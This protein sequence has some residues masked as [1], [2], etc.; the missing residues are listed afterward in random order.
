[1][2]NLIGIISSEDI[3]IL[4]GIIMILF[5]SGS[6]VIKVLGMGVK[7]LSRIIV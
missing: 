1:M 3:A 2:L 4:F 5:G 6:K 7:L